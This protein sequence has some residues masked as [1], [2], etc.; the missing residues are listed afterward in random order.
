MRKA[1]NFPTGESSGY[2]SEALMNFRSILFSVFFT[3]F[4]ASIFGQA[5]LNQSNFASNFSP[6][7]IKPSSGTEPTAVI[8]SMEQQAFQI[9]NAKRAE[10]GLS[11][12]EWNAEIAELARMHSQNMAGK[13]FFSHTD[14]DGNTVDARAENVGLGDWK[15]IGENIAY[16]RGHKDP[17]SAAVENWMKSTGHR[18]NVLNE[19]YNESA[20]GVAVA[21]DGSYYFTQVFMLIGK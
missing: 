12:L 11:T 21:A 2:R 1:W 20:V 13:K 16:L 14:L 9:L 17:A 18:Q 6:A 15:A 7:V 3:V 5:N 4:A 10:I 8:S 19:R